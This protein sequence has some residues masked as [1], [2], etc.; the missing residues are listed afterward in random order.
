MKRKGV[1]HAVLLATFVVFMVLDLVFLT[2]T[3]FLPQSPP[4]GE[5]PEIVHV[6]PAVDIPVLSPVI[7]DVVPP[8]PVET[9]LPPPV[10][11]VIEPAIVV[12]IVEEE[13]PPV[14]EVVVEERSEDVV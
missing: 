9:E 8:A 4:V 10:V 1:S 13:A 5:E 6:L 3:C 11:E 12:P 7:P 2:H 14:A